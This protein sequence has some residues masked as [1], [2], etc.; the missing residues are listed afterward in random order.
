M[1]HHPKSVRLTA[2]THE[3]LK[4]AA[5]A[6]GITPSAF[7]RIAVREQLSHEETN[8]ELCQLRDE[9][10]STLSRIDGRCRSISNA[11]QATYAVLDTLVKYIL[12]VSP[13]PSDLPAQAMGRQRYE[14]FQRT[15]LKALQGDLLRAFAAVQCDTD[16]H[17]PDGHGT[18]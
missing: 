12:T 13:A 18:Q 17:D 10:A 4:A 16:G 1:A 2:A 6:Q 8:T 14:Q 5:A 9:L 7:I 11:Q 15:A 3:K